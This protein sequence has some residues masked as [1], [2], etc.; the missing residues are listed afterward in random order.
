[1]RNSLLL[2]IRL[3]EATLL[4][5]TLQRWI[6]QS[7]KLPHHANKTHCGHK[8]RLEEIKSIHLLLDANIGRC[9][10]MN[11]ITPILSLQT[12]ADVGAFPNL[13]FTLRSETDLK[14]HVPGTSPKLS[15]NN[16]RLPTAN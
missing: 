6:V 15:L 11:A 14:I 12:D 7:E 4:E 8:P 10:V 16:G 1:M 13:E 3:F 5:C 9:A 2:V